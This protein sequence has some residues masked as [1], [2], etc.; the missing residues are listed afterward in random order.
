MLWRFLLDIN[1]QGKPIEPSNDEFSLLGIDR[2]RIEGA[3]GR[4]PGF[5]LN[6]R[7]ERL[8]APRQ[9]LINTTTAK[10]AKK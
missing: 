6:G 3:F 2:G 5:F 8:I 9:R 10:I 4:S 7:R 1:T